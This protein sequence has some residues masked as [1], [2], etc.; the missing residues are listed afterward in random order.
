MSPR[1]E[2]FGATLRK[3]RPEDFGATL[4]NAAPAPEPSALEQF[5]EL[6]SKNDPI[7]MGAAEAASQAQV[8]EIAYDGAVGLS[9]GLSMGGADEL[10]GSLPGSSIAEQQMIRDAARKRSPI[11]YDIGHSAGS[12]VPAAL[13][14]GESALEQF[15]QGAL[16]GGAGGF[17]GSDGSLADRAKAGEQG[18]ALAALLH[19]AGTGFGSVAP[20]A[21]NALIPGAQ[22]LERRAQASTEG[23]TGPTFKALS[24]KHGI[25]GT[26]DDLA[27]FALDTVP[28][29]PTFL[30][31][32]IPQKRDWFADQ[33]AA[34][35]DQTGAN[36]GAAMDQLGQEVP[37]ALSLQE[38]ADQMDARGAPY[39]NSTVRE[40]QAKAAEMAGLRDRVLA[41]YGDR[42]PIAAGGEMNEVPDVY[43]SPADLQ[44]EKVA[45]AREGWPADATTSVSDAKRAEFYR[46]ASRVPRQALA[47]ATQ[48]ATPE[49][50]NMVQNALE[51]HGNASMLAD[52]SALAA[53]K[54]EGQKRD[55]FMK[56]LMGPVMDRVPDA[57]SLAMHGAGSA[58]EQFSMMGQGA[59]MTMQSAAGS[60]GSAAAQKLSDRS[61]G[62]QLE[63]RVTSLAQTQPQALGPYAQRFQEA[64][65]SQDPM[66]VTA[67]IYQLQE[68]PVW[69]TQYLPALRAEGMQ[70]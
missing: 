13:S 57:S 28:E 50:Q 1:P 10:M 9:Q 27:Q 26:R 64:L 12:M 7:A 3:P 35:A 4:R 29:R 5:A 25:A 56:L 55:S 11:A 34:Q 54:N 41:K 15:A 69:R 52:A 48:L 47:D 59:G 67:L 31:M 36:V 66:R 16:Q 38:F 62:H 6:F 68:D 8:P 39:L 70:P 17:L 2:D 58:L 22:S 44:N 20:A 45:W 53:K 18:V 61:M 42:A 23:L 63:Q 49:T 14:A 65:Q 46:D 33:R 24:E 19:G 60:M 30:G 37:Q 32:P 43:M 40:E 21:A 51:E